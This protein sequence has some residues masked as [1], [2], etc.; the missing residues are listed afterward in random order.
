VKRV[1]DSIVESVAR[2]S[3]TLEV[4][5]LPTYALPLLRLSV[6]MGSLKA[7][8]DAG[9]F[10]SVGGANHGMVGATPIQSDVDIVSASTEAQGNCKATQCECNGAVHRHG[11]PPELSLYLFA[12]LLFTCDAL[13]DGVWKSAHHYLSLQYQEDCFWCRVSS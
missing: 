6:C 3:V 9:Y 8:S 7:C 5:T 1:V 11:A 4:L 2:T 10:H 12:Q 13:N